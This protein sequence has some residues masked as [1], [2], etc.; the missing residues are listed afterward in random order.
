MS[1]LR[2]GKGNAM[3]TKK[4]GIVKRG[5]ATDKSLWAVMRAHSWGS[6]AINGTSLV[7]PPEG[8]HRFIPVFETRNQAVT[9]H[10]SDSDV[11]ELRCITPESAP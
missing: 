5:E 9:W 11:F 7:A 1:R 3:T 2:A 8:P 6:I 4:Q 10:G